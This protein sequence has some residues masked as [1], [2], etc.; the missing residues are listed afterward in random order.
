[1]KVDEQWL[2]K[3]IDELI[4]D[5]NVFIDAGMDKAAAIKITRETTSLTDR[6]FQRVINA[7]DTGRR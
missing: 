1:M 4:T 2:D 6:H 7:F 5:I 3:R